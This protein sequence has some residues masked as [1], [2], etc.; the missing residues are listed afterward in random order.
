MITYAKEHQKDEIIYIWDVSFPDT[1]PAYNDLYFEDKYR[2]ENTLVYLLEDKI[3]SC[4]QMLPYNITYYNHICKT[5]YI[6]GA[7]TLPD[8]QKRGIMGELL[9]QSFL[10]MKNRGDVFTILIPQEDD[11]AEYYQKYG[12]EYCFEYLFN[13][14][15]TLPMDIP[16]CD[17]LSVVELDDE[18]IEEAHAY[19]QQYCNKQNL[20]ILK[21]FDDFRIIWEDLKLLY[22]TILVCYKSG[23]VC[24][25]C[26][27][28]Y[29]AGGL[30][31]KDLFTD[32]DTIKAYL[33]NDITKKYPE[34]KIFLS[35]PVPVSFSGDGEISY[36]GMARILDAEKA[37][38]LYASYYTD[39]KITIKVNDKQIAENNGIFHLS[40]GDCTQQNNKDFD[41]EVSIGMLTRLLFGYH[42][43]ELAPVYNIFTPQHPYMSLMLD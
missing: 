40:K 32:D 39:L 4:L 35:N 11:L 1:F 42:I 17:T 36:H 22:G 37:L 34:R 41:V 29:F 10:E 19:Y 24:G 20:F 27:Y 30:S 43:D 23:Q 25:I 14:N 12:Y 28:T 33:L 21:S 31:V 5:S 2:K 15:M 9:S 6:S 16:C 38:Q 13:H 18:N 26:F 3:V 8:Y 7:A